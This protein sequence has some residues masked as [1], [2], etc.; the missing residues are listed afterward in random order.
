SEFKV[1]QA[2]AVKAGEFQALLF[3]VACKPEVVVAEGKGNLWACDEMSLD[4][5]ADQVSSELLSEARLSHGILPGLT[6]GSRQQA[7]PPDAPTR[8]NRALF[9]LG[10]TL[11]GLVLGLLVALSSRTWL[12]EAIKGRGSH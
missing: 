10:G 11:V 5:S 6:I 3:S 2:H 4:V 9:A 8:Q 1:S 12:G 7:A